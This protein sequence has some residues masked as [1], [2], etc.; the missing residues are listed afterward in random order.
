MG[1]LWFSNERTIIMS[2]GKEQLAHLFADHKHLRPSINAVLHGCCGRAIADSEDRP[3]VAQ[4]TIEPCVF[5]GGDP[6]HPAAREM[7]ED[8]SGDQLIW[9]DSD[10]WQNLVFETHGE[11]VALQEWTAFSWESL[12]PQHLQQLVSRVRK[13]FHIERIDIDLARRIPSEVHRNLIMPTVFR[14]TSD[15]VKRGFGFCAVSNEGRIVS[16]A[17]SGIVSDG[18]IEIQINTNGPYRQ[19][20]LATAV[21]AALVAHSLERGIE[22]HWDTTDAISARLAEKLGYV[23]HETYEVIEI[24][25]T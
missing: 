11:R 6:K 20:G 17:I 23:E 18:A 1:E 25:A 24:A 5:F 4:L 12:D 22:P 13:G 15:F 3:Q 7:V 10:D 19:K 21:G 9:T 8:L 14:S 2:I 16:A